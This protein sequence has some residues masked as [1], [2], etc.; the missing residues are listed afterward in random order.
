MALALRA[1]TQIQILDC[2]FYGFS[3]T[4]IIRIDSCSD[5]VIAANH[6]Y[7]CHLSCEGPAQLTCIDVDDNRL[8]DGSSKLRIIGNII[9]NI[10]VSPAFLTT[11]GNQ[12]DGINIS[13]ET[14]SGH[15]IAGNT[16]DT[17]GDGIDCFGHECMIE[18]NILQ[19]CHNFGVKLIHGAHRNIVR[20]NRIENPG[21][22]GIVLTGSG[23]NATDTAQNIVTENRISGVGAHNQ[24]PG[25]TTFGIKLEDDHGERIARDNIIRSNTIERGPRME[26]GILIADRASGNVITDNSVEGYH[27]ADYF[28]KNPSLQTLKR[29]VEK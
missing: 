6:F 15:L 18:G 27:R 12:T 2:T 10:T 11:H 26:I 3:K 21:L 7:N 14:S 28:L 20:D 9:R 25:A 29:K 1:S 24:W 19:N 13:H 17:V 23:A 16:I 22:G 4:K 8:R 5:C